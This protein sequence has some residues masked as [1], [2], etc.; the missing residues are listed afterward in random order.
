MKRD[1]S[2]LP[3][4][5]NVK[6]D[7]PPGADG[8]PVVT[9]KKVGGARPG[10]GRKKKAIKFATQN[11]YFNALVDKDFQRIYQALLDCAL[12]HFVEE[13]D[14][15][16]NTRVYFSKPN[17]DAIKYMLNRRLGVPTPKL[18]PGLTPPDGSED[19]I[20]GVLVVLPQR[21]PAPQAIE[22]EIVKP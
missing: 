8:R 16:G 20:T 11:D 12:G 9:K 3:D 6:V 7:L 21:N 15:N 14:L 5:N 4:L 1:K 22:G 18:F 13:T 10:A 17:P 19:G 2:D